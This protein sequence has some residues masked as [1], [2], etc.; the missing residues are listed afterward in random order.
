MH[1]RRQWQPTPV[2]LPGESQG[3]GAWWAA[4]CGVAQSQT[5]LK[6]LSCSSSSKRYTVCECVCVCLLVAQS[7]LTLLQPHGLQAAELL[8]PW[9]SPGKNI[10]VG[11]HL[12]LQGILST[13]G[14][15]AHALSPALACGFFTTGAT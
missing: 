11:C 12:C 5:R 1:W 9:D 10:G 8:C 6:R 13:Q 15:N 4:V 2:F 3:R 7:C 14:S